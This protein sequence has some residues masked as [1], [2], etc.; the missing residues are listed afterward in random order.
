MKDHEINQAIAESVGW[1]WFDHP[2]TL[3]KTKGWTLPNSVA[4]NPDGELVSPNSVPD[5]C[6]DLNAM[7]EAEKTFF[8]SSNAWEYF[9]I[10]LICVLKASSMVELDVMVCLLQATA[11]Q[12]GE[13]YLRTIGKWRGE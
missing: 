2:D 1:K 4:T 3:A 9:T 12:R 6:N 8:R 10:N 7:H 11:R 5:Y 13:A